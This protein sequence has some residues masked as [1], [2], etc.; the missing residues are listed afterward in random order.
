MELF[1]DDT[2]A[3]VKATDVVRTVICDVGKESAGAAGN[4]AGRAVERESGAH[5]QAAVILCLETLLERFR[6]PW[7]KG[8]V[9]G[10]FKMATEMRMSF[11][12]VCR[13]QLDDMA[14]T[15]RRKQGQGAGGG[16]RPLASRTDHPLFN[17]FRL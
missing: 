17:G 11:N 12:T 8:P 2:Y 5:V 16:Q 13:N 7:A 9:V 3:F 15:L 4:E 1:T 6:L 10:V 14:T